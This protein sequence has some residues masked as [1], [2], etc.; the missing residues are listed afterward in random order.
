MLKAEDMLKAE[1]NDTENKAKEAKDTEVECNL[2]VKGELDK[3]AKTE[4]ECKF[5]VEDK[6]EKETKMF[7]DGLYDDEDDD[8]DK[9][10]FERRKKKNTTN[11]FIF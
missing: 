1:T 2:E 7:V 11:L 3:T 9:P 10:L 6:D 5:E 8:E 4:V